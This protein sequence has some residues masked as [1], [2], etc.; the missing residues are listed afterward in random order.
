MPSPPPPSSPDL[1]RWGRIRALFDD[2]VDRP[3]GAA[4][5]GW[6]RGACGGDDG[7]YGDVAALLAADAEA[8]PLLDQDPAAVLEDVVP[9]PT[10]AGRVVGPYRVIRELGRGG[11]GA[12]YLAE[13]DDV[14]RRVA[15]KAVRG[16]LAAPEHR[17]RFLF[18]RRA[19]ARLEH[20]N[21]ARLLDAGLADDGTPWFAMELVDG[22][23]IT[24]Y[25]DRHAVNAPGRVALFAQACEAVRHAHERLVVP[26]A[27]ERFRRP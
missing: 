3:C 19:L 22:Q 15:L 7:L 21:I 1:T 27:K 10:L 14:R 13:R 23:A 11:M 16:N 9:P 5:D 17:A 18:E 26:A 12:V 25:A 24:A 4:R 20:P 2:A 6:L 8:S